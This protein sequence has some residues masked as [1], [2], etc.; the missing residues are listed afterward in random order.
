MRK[1]MKTNFILL[2]FQLIA[3]AFSL[4]ISCNNP[5]REVFDFLNLTGALLYNNTSQHT[6]YVQI[7]GYGGADVKVSFNNNGEELIIP[8]DK[9]EAPQPFG[10]R[11]PIGGSYEVKL[12]GTTPANAMNCKIDSTNTSG[13]ISN[14]DIT[15]TA[16][17]KTKWLKVA[18]G[19]YHT[20]AI[21]G[22]GSLWAWGQND[23]NQLGIGGDHACLLPTNTALGY[24]ISCQLIP[25]QV[26]T[27]TGW[28]D[29]SAGRSFSMGVRNG[30]LY[31]WG[32][33]TLGELGTGDVNIYKIPYPREA[34]K[35]MSAGGNHG[36]VIRSDGSLFSSGLNDAWQ[37]NSD[38][39][40]QK[41]C[42]GTTTYNCILTPTQ[43]GA[44]TTWSFVSG[45][46]IQ[47]G[48]SLAMKSDKTLWAWGAGALGQMGQTV[49]DAC[50]PGAANC[51]KIPVQIAG[52]WSSVSAG[53]EH[54][55]GIKTDGSMWGWG[56]NLYGS[57]G[58]GTVV[59]VFAPVDVGGGLTAWTSISA[60]GYHSL[61]IK[62]NGTLWS[63]GINNRGQLGNTETGTCST[64][65][66]SLSPVQVGTDT[67]WQ[68]IA[69]GDAGSYAIKSDGTLWAWGRN[70]FGQIGV[71]DQTNRTAPA[72][73]TFP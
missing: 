44:E 57:V 71:N 62:N 7:N 32:K 29:I 3:A 24:I 54:N 43:I 13:I 36:L 59:N 22:D 58:N 12:T 26:G 67:D 18:A 51:R 17:C 61:A 42:G 60:G 8:R 33:N 66:C 68:S 23:W 35:H 10:I 14:S 9:F 21:R 6:V 15:I 50:N 4:L 20:L 19:G 37:T 27:E 65:P 53:G 11:V 38:I 63:W 1:I 69:G 72:E 45:G 31:T 56:Y 70:D 34:L 16:T 48:W 2:K 47:S 46:G 28:T 25:K 52:T 73:V 41:T 30:N 40:N 39:T 55:L 49:T 64:Y 5:E